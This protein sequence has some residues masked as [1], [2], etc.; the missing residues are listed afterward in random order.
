M[1]RFLTLSGF[2]PAP[3]A[4]AARIVRR[5]LAGGDGIV[6]AYL[7]EGGS[8]NQTRER[9]E[10]WLGRNGFKVSAITWPQAEAL[11]PDTVANLTAGTK[12]GFF[13]LYQL[14][15]KQGM[16][17]LVLEA[18]ASPPL[19]FWL[20]GRKEVL[21]E[22]DS[23]GLEDYAFL[24]LEAQGA[25]IAGRATRV[26]AGLQ[27]PMWCLIETQEG[28]KDGQTLFAVHR[29][30]PCVYAGIPKGRE[31]KDHLNILARKAKSLGG[32]LVRAFTDVPQGRPQN[33]NDRATLLQQ[34]KEAGVELVFPNDP[35]GY[36]FRPPDRRVVQLGLIRV[37]PSFSPPRQGPVLLGIVSEQPV[38]I[39]ASFLA[40]APRHVYLV[41][42]KDLEERLGRLE[43]A[44]EVFEEL[45]AQV[46]VAVV[47]GPQAM[48][49]VEDLFRPVVAQAVARGFPV[50]ANIN[51]GTKL[52]ALGLLEALH[53]SVGVEYLVGN[54]LRALNQGPSSPVPWD[55]VGPEQ[56]LR[57]FGYR[58]KPS[59]EWARVQLNKRVL[60]LA[61]ELLRNP[62]D[63]SR[64]ENFLRVWQN[65]FG[66]LGP[67]PVGK[68]PAGKAR[69]LA[70]EYVVYFHLK[71]FLEHKSAVRG[72]VAPPGHLDP[73]KPVHNPREVD[74]VFWLGGSLGFVEC[75]QNLR[76][77]LNRHHE[78]AALW[79]L[80]ERFGGLFGKGILVARK[81]GWRDHEKPP[82]KLLS[83]DVLED[84]NLRVFGF[85]RRQRLE[86]G[87]IWA[88]PEDLEKA[89]A[90]WLPGTLP[91]P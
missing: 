2:D 51:G 36:H 56:V 27:G 28:E 52:M 21:S 61:E 78:D 91:T 25:K 73:V 86:K 63:N 54:D 72:K 44:K 79:L 53:P 60:F 1:V 22:A 48:K 82:E 68:D 62:D 6:E 57:L 66:G 49:E 12:E 80:Q 83:T 26:P 38:P 10:K 29:G 89:F 46:E 65:A 34:A 18:H 30:R 85:Q 59:P 81:A 19:L 41:S 3:V 37:R 43:A 70:L 17:A 20:D 88:F 40:H 76:D 15:R 32:Q 55:K 67:N 58:L 50:V 8:S 23:L 74:G 75:K 35:L 16:G 31:F 7:L 87:M 4:W 47:S 5:R 13:R 84:R 14:A 64:A 90:D 42:T 69:G 24:Y 33:E 71:D 11:G 39:L 77:A 9:L 45:G